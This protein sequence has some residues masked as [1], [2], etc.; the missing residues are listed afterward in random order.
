MKS[1]QKQLS[2]RKITVDIIKLKFNTKYPPKKI[3]D[4]KSL[5]T[6]I[7]KKLTQFGIVPI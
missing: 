5:N 2:R 7:E 4:L 1:E 3:F 6:N